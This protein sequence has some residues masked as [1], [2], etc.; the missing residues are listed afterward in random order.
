[1]PTPLK[2]RTD[3]HSYVPKK[4]EVD[5]LLDESSARKKSQDS[6]TILRKNFGIILMS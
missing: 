3:K 1:M 6:F 2:P 4:K 5:S